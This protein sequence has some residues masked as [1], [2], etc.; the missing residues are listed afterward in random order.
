[1]STHRLIVFTKPTDGKEAE[2]NRW[3]DEV[4]LPDILA[5]EG[6]V[7]AQRFA[8]AD[9]QIGDVG[10]TAPGRYLAIYEIEADSLQAALD[11]LNA[12]S[13]TMEMSD[14]LDLDA[15]TAIAFSAI[16]ERQEAK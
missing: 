4:H 12:G 11:R 14:A 8:L 15:A 9:T 5:T 2:F 6:F 13:E 16:G 1:M 10:D 7:A 3:Y